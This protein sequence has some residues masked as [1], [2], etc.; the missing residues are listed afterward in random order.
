MTCPRCQGFLY[1]VFIRDQWATFVQ[2]VCVNC[3]DRQQRVPRRVVPERMVGKGVV[4]HPPM[5][6]D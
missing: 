2:R 4:C 6:V 1:D 3:G 5:A